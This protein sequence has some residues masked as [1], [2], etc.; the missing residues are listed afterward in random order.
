MTGGAGDADYDTGL[1]TFRHAPGTVM[2]HLAMSDLPDWRAGPEPC[3]D[4]YVT[5]APTLDAMTLAYQQPLAGLL[6]T[7]PMI[8]VGQ[9]SAIDPSRAPEGKRTLWLQVHIVPSDIKGDAAGQIDAADWDTA[10][11][12]FSQRVL[13]IVE[14]HAPGLRDR[15]LGMRCVSPLDLEADNPNLVGAIRFAAVII[16]P[17]M[18]F[19]A[20]CVVTP[21]AACRCKRLTTLVQPSGLA[22]A[23]VRGPA[24]CLARC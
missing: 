21:M 19:S 7:E 6:P 24:R 22:Q 10:L 9:P 1:D 23:R 13:D 16:C 8:V 17:R 20:R 2:I 4:A 15:I 18:R 12:T 5:I 3:D 11:A 14:R